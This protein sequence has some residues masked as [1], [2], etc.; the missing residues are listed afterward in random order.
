M[1]ISERKT[2]W[3][4]QSA[5]QCW[6]NRVQRTTRFLFEIR[7]WLRDSIAQQNWSCNED[8]FR[9]IGELVRKET[10][11]CS[12]FRRQQLQLLFEQRNEIHRNQHCEQFLSSQT[13]V[14]EQCARKSHE[15]FEKWIWPQIGDDVEPIAAPREDVEMGNDEDDIGSVC[16]NWCAACVEGRGV[17]G[18]HR[19]ELL[20]EEERERTTSIVAFDYG[21][22]TQENADAFPF[23][24]CRDSRYGQTGAACCERKGPTACS[25]PK[26][27][28]FT[29]SF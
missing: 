16:R 22:M 25:T 20:E 13:S 2:R 19:V 7:R 28:V 17:G 1:S 6:R 29:E 18:Q 12:L 27:L 5:V 21:F 10:A 3:F 11:H 4:T 14:A 24:I 23:L 15:N 8:A 9:T 26:I